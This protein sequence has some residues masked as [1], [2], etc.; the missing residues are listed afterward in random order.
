MLV[1]SRGLPTYL[2]SSNPQI[3]LWHRQLGHISNARVVQV[4]KLVDRIDLKEITIEPIDKPQS[5]DSEPESDS[6]VDKLS[7]INKSMEL[8]INNVEELCKACIKS[9]H[10]RIVKSKR[11]TP[12]MRRLQEIYADLL[13]LHKPASISSKNYV[14]LLLDEFT[15]KSWIILLRSKDEFFDTFK[16]W[17]PR[18][19]SCGNKLDC[20]WINGEREFTSTAFQSFCEERGIKIGYAAPYMYK[21]NRIVEQC[22]KTLVQMKDSLFIDSKLP[23]QFWPEVMDTANY[24]RNQLPTKRTEDKT[25]I[26]PKEAWTEVRQNL[27]HIQIF[28]SRVSTYILSEKHSKSD[29]CKTW[30]GIFIG[31]TDTIKHLRTWTSK[32]HQMLIAS[33]P[34]VNKSKWEAELLVDNPIPPPKL[35]QQPAGK[36]KPRGWPRKRPRIEDTIIEE[37]ASGDELAQ[38]I[39]QTKRMRIHFLHDLKPRTDLGGTSGKNLANKLVRPMQELAKLVTE[40]NSKVREPKTYDKAIKD[41]VHGNR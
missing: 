16:L 3:R 41:F 6:D 9:K 1:Q 31:Y 32:T 18:K 19:E 2:L 25:I 37:N 27:E 14:A 7:P 33:K 35:L 38:A 23:N 28:G 20:L 29:V 13:G 36:P 4:S 21:E 24:F 8:N 15:R 40:T 22:W 10:T 17:L 30:N 34:I 12:T 11:M 26:I 39:V 5:S